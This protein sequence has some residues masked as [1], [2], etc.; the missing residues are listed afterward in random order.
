LFSFPPVAFLSGDP[1]PGWISRLFVVS[2]LAHLSS[3]PS[4]PVSVFG[5]AGVCRGN[6]IKLSHMFSI[7]LTVKLSFTNA[8]ARK[9]GTK[10]Q[11]KKGPGYSHGKQ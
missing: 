8:V 5:L 6:T 10:A 7:Q 9:S 1:V 2:H 11:S 3:A 4:F